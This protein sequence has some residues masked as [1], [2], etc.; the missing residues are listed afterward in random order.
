MA[1]TLE[2][3]APAHAGAGVEGLGADV[4]EL[5]TEMEALRLALEETNAAAGGELPGGDARVA[6]RPP[7]PPPD[8]RP[9]RRVPP[10]GR[11]S[12]T[13]RPTG[14]GPASSPA[15]ATPAR[16]A[17][18]AAGPGARPTRPRTT[19]GPTPRPRS[20]STHD[21]FGS[22]AESPGVANQPLAPWMTGEHQA[23]V[24]DAEVAMPTDTLAPPPPAAPAARAAD[25]ARRPT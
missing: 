9:R 13:A 19:T 11:S 1:R 22:V 7:D 15:A 3:S 12:T 14:P 24:I 23:I 4:D 16:P 20:W 25:P 6:V 18:F 21:V 17:R 2:L 10:R 5:V 8:P